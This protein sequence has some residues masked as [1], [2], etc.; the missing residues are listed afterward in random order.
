MHSQINFGYPF[1]ISYGH[2]LLA[3]CLLVILAAVWALKGPNILLGIIGVVFVWALSAGLIVRFVF[4]L[5]GRAKLPT[6][7]FLASGTGKVLDMGAGTGRSALMVLEARP[8]ATVVALDLF[9]DSYEEH[10]G[11][12][13]SQSSTLDQ[14]RAALMRNLSAAGVESRATI[15]PGDMRHMPLESS[16]FDAIVSAY[17]IDHLGRKGIDEALSE[18]NRVLKPGGEFLLMVIAKDGWLTYTFGPLLVHAHMTAGDFWSTKLREAGFEILEEGRQ[19]VT[20]YILARK[21]AASR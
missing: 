12:P 21:T 14:G 7:S 4:D 2:L 13:V 8:Q 16:S 3:A 20:K 11:K 19:P 10:F 5:N 17:A 9:G 6:A 18:A 1:L 15:Q